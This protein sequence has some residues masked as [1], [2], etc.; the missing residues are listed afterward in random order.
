MMASCVCFDVGAFFGLVILEEDLCK[1]RVVVRLRI[2][3]LLF[4]S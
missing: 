4:Q 1:E 3:V 2:E